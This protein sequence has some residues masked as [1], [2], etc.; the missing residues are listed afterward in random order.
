MVKREQ[1]KW[2]KKK[3]KTKYYNTELLQATQIRN[4]H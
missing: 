4:V 2:E 1:A 3:K